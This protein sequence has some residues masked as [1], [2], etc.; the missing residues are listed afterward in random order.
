MGTIYRQE[1]GRDLFEAFAEDIAEPLGMEDFRPEESEYWMEAQSEHPAYLFRISSH[2]LGRFGLRYLRR[3]LWG[4]KRIL[5]EEWVARSTATHSDTGITGGFGYLWWTSPEGRGFPFVR[6]PPGSFSAR[7]TGPQ[8]VI[9]VP[10]L[11]AVVVH[12]VDTDDGK[13]ISITDV[14]RLLREIFSAHTGWAIYVDGPR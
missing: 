8:L 14:G 3:G 12:R 1:T 9:V 6:L 10:E 13:L 2:D 7:G 5:A 4:E 11:D